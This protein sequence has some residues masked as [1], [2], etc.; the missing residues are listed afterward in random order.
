M[1]KNEQ[2]MTEKWPKNDRKIFGWKFRIRNS[3]HFGDSEFGIQN[4]EIFLKIQNSEFGV[5]KFENRPKPIPDG[6][7]YVNSVA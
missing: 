6:Y 7:A 3:A 1:P 5:R 4:S 2:K